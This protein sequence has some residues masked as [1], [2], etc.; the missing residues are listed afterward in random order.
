[1]THPNVYK[2]VEDLIVKRLPWG[3]RILDAP[4]GNG[5][6][7]DRFMR[8]GY[9]VHGLD[10]EPLPKNITPQSFD[11]RPGSFDFRIADLNRPLPFPDKQF[12]AVICVEGIEHIENHFSLI[13]EFHRVLEPEGKLIITTPNICSLRS[14]MRFLWSGFY[15]KV[16]LPLNENRPTPLHHITPIDYPHLRYILHTNGFR[17]EALAGAHAKPVSYFYL[18]LAAGSLLYTLLAFRKEKDREQRKKNRSIYREMNSPVLLLNEI[19][20]VVAHRRP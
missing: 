19:L 4:C 16:P 1:M 3:S 12:H 11:K 9:E 10:C 15:H 20:A 2:T 7:S 5:I 17:V 6:L 18:P 14:R 13:R 8:L